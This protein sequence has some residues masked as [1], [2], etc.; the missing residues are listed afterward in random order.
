MV[1]NG[2]A[3]DDPHYPMTIERTIGKWHV[4]MVHNLQL[5][6]SLTRNTSLPLVGKV[7]QEISNVVIHAHTHRWRDEVVGSTRL[8]NPGTATKPQFGGV[9]RT[10]ARLH[11]GRELSV[12]KLSLPKFPK[13]TADM[14]SP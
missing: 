7:S 2:N 4:T 11:F 13:R 1:V 9:E 10:M 5:F 12:Q 3:P 6:P 8:I 14:I